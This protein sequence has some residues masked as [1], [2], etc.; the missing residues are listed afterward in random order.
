MSRIKSL[1]LLS[2][3]TLAL[4][5]WSFAA[6]VQ[7]AAG[8]CL[9]RLRSFPTITGA[10]AANPAPNV[11]FVCPGTYNEQITI[12]NGVTLEGITSGDSDQ[13]IIAPPAG[14]LTASALSSNL[15]EI[16]NFQI[17]VTNASGP[18][19][20]SNLTVDG[21]GNGVAASGS[22]N[23]LV[24]ILYQN[25]SGTVNRVT[26]QNET[27]NFNGVGISAEA[28]SPISVENSNIQNFDS[29][30]IVAAFNATI[31][32]NNLSGLSGCGCFGI[33]LQGNSTATVT[34][35]FISATGTAITTGSKIVGSITGNTL[36]SNGTGISPVSTTISVTSNKILNA[37]TGIE[38]SCLADPNVHSN[39]IVNASFG[40]AHV[41]AAV[42]TPN[43]YFG[44]GTIRS[45]GC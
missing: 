37:N 44:V 41:P 11:V 43:S 15:L 36:I 12:T 5:P 34:G 4:V 2:V 7:Y 14:G 10:L 19:N 42:V 3:L 21:T 23:G 25:S 29:I 38:F 32:S 30:G 40:V 33:F 9:P 24:G 6:V 8:T 1:L 16:V 39:T 18:V 20:I 26:I 22:G 35:N 17:L 28:A 13:A 45:G 31:K 27:D